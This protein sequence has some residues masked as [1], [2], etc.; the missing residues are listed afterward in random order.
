MNKVGIG[1]FLL[2]LALL[3]FQNCGDGAFQA[4]QSSYVKPPSKLSCEEELEVLFES[5]F[6]NH[7]RQ[8]GCDTCHNGATLLN[9]ADNDVKVAYDAFNQRAPSYFREKIESEN[10]QQAILGYNKQSLISTL[11]DQEKDFAE[12]EESCNPLKDISH[13]SE[14]RVV[15]FF[16]EPEIPEGAT[17]DPRCDYNDPIQLEV[18][19]APFSS[20]NPKTSVLQWDL[21]AEDSRLEGVVARLEVAPESPQGFPIGSPKY[22]CPNQDGYQVGALRFVSSLN[23]IRVKNVS[24]QING[25]DQENRHY[26]GVELVIEP[27]EAEVFMLGPK[28]GF[29][30]FTM[31]DSPVLATDQWQLQI[32][33]IEVLQ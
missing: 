7:L 12:L 13:L 22:V 23:K 4:A 14:A 10:H 28:G 21:G 11:E 8:V 27:G 18:I 29:T 32:E 9:F 24:I 5:S 19:Q 15:D 17:S 26:Y 33:E 1:F 25:N 2:G 6:Y 30:I 16:A 20:S 31:S 3:A